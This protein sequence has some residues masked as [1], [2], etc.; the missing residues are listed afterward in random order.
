[1]YSSKTFKT[2]CPQCKA[3]NAVNWSAWDS[4]CRGNDGGYSITCLKCHADFTHEVWRAIAAKELKAMAK[5]EAK[6]D[7]EWE[8]RNAPERARR[9]EEMQENQ[10]SARKRGL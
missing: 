9:L 5:A 3:K 10:R 4:D 6:R 1:M 7:A 2:A 8:K